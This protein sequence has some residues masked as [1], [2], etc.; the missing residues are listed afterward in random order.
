M[1][2]PWQSQGLQPQ[3]AQ[4]GMPGPPAQHQVQHA[5]ISAQPHIQGNAGANRNGLGIPGAAP[6]FGQTGAPFVHQAQPVSMVPAAP[7]AGGA[8]GL[9]S[10]LMSALGQFSLADAQNFVQRL[11]GIEGIVD[12]VGKAQ[13]VVQSVAQMAPMIKL[14][15]SVF[16][17]SDDDDDDEAAAPPR[18]RRRRSRRRPKPK[19]KSRRRRRSSATRPATARGRGRRNGTGTGTGRRRRPNR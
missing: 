6:G 11:G 8:A 16:G 19:P 15:F 12:K 17:K 10:K 1:N 13:K 2:Q 14:M 9:G 5:Q 3:Q 4:G 7:A 18:R